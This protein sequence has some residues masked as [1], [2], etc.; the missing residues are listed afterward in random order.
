MLGGVTWPTAEIMPWNSGVYITETKGWNTS[1]RVQTP[2]RRHMDGAG[3]FRGSLGV[4]SI[5]QQP[6]PLGPSE[7]WREKWVQEHA[8]KIRKA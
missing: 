8:G 6:P 7:F 5:L 4:S 2:W 3:G 1:G